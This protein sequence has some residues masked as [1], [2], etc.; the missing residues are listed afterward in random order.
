MW[1]QLPE[2]L[3]FRLPGLL[4]WRQQELLHRMCKG[5][6]I[7]HENI[8]MDFWYHISILLETLRFTMN[9]KEKWRSENGI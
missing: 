2:G 5:A 8:E 1:M 3:T 4:L 7:L 6:L 9:K